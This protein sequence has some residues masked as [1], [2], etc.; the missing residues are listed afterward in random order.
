MSQVAGSY[1]RF[2]WNKFQSLI[3]PVA[4]SEA[5]TW[6]RL[7]DQTAKQLA[8]L[9]DH[10]VRDL[11]SWPVVE[12]RAV[13]DRAELLVALIGVRIF[14]SKKIWFWKVRLANMDKN[15]KSAKK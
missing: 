12:F 14:S 9:I 4:I 2:E 6:A 7:L 5:R 8:F 1:S 13:A 15:G 11:V 3:Q 10:H